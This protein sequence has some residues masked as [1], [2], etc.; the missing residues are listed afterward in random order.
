MSSEEPK[1]GTLTVYSER[2]STFQHM[3]HIASG[4]EQR[5]RLVTCQPNSDLVKRYM[6]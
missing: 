6:E 1:R 3:K 4:N 2:Q 5:P